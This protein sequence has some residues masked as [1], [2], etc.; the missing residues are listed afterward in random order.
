MPASVIKITKRMAAG[1]AHNQR[2]YRDAD[3]KQLFFYKLHQL[4]DTSPALNVS[5]PTETLTGHN[6]FI[7]A[8]DA[9]SSLSP[10]TSPQGR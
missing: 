3:W 6:V 5:V 10:S 4:L 9:S 7:R 2:P 8:A 1:L